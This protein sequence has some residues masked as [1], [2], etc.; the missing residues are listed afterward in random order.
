MAEKD[1]RP[2]PPPTSAPRFSLLVLRQ[3]DQSLEVYQPRV[4]ELGTVE[5]ERCQFG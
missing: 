3:V 4:G 5:T 2:T 1:P